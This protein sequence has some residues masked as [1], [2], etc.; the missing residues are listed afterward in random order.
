MDLFQITG[1]THFFGGLRAVSDFNL[2]MTSG[3]LVGLIGPNGAGKTTV[4]NLISGL[5]KPAA[6]SIRFLHFDI[7]GLPPHEIVRRGI[8][9]VPEGRGIFGNL[10][11][12]ENLE[13]A[14]TP[15]RRGLKAGFDH[16]FALFPRLEER[17]RQQAGTLSG[18][19]Q[20]MLAVGRALCAG[21]HRR[22]RDAGELDGRDFHTIQLYDG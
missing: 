15:N 3:E 16:V 7:T 5:Y 22:V 11:V 21:A 13:V 18:G 4:F 2:R 8:V 19:E 10:T 14:S 9:Q 6:G 12:R 17:L 1:L 20:Q